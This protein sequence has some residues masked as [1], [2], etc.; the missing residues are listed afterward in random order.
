MMKMNRLTLMVVSTTLQVVGCG[1]DNG[2]V[3]GV[4][5]GAGGAHAVP[6]TGGRSSGGNNSLGKGFGL[7]LSDQATLA[8]FENNTITYNSNGAARALA[9][10]VHQLR[11]SG[12]K[13]AD[14]G[15][16]NIVRVEAS[17]T[18]GVS[19]DVTWPNLAPAIYRVT[20]INGEGGN[21][22]F[23][24]SG[25][26]DATTL[27]GNGAKASVLVGDLFAEKAS[28]LR[29]KN[30]RFTGPSNGDIDIQVKSPSNLAQEG[31]N[32]GTGSNGDLKIDRI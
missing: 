25:P 12:N 2:N 22:I 31:S 13:L 28:A 18:Y 1:D 29:V 20:G 16:G 21:Q 4:P 9:P 8:Q 24:A 30:V 14:N 17:R 27:C 11:G 26:P 15:H 23:N 5:Y 3:A 7:T 32:S 6:S 19:E 10:S